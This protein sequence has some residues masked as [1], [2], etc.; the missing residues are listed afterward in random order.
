MNFW[1][2]NVDRLL[3]FQDKK[4]L[5]NAGSVTHEAMEQKVKEVYTLFDQRRKTTEAQAEDAQELEE[6]RALERE[7]MDKKV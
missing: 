3:V 2:E 5:Q 1:R 6:L 4:I 7:I